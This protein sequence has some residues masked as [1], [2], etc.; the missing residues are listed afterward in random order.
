VTGV[1]LQLKGF[2]MHKDTKTPSFQKQSSHSRKIFSNGI[3]VS[4]LTSKCKN[5][6]PNGI[7]SYISSGSQGSN[8]RSLL[9]I[10]PAGF[11]V[12]S[13]RTRYESG[14]FNATQKYNNLEI[15]LQSEYP[16]IER[17]LLFLLGIAHIAMRKYSYDHYA[18]TAEAEPD[19]NE[20]TITTS[21]S[22]LRNITNSRSND[23]DLIA[24]LH[25][26]YLLDFSV[27]DHQ[28]KS[29]EYRPSE[30]IR[31]SIK[32]SGNGSTR[33]IV[34]TLH[35]LLAKT[36]I[37]FVECDWVVPFSLIYLSE[38]RAIRGNGHKAARLLHVYFSQSVAQG[39]TSKNHSLKTLAEKIY[40]YESKYISRQ[41]LNSVRKGLA[42]L[43]ALGW[44]VSEL[45]N[46]IFCVSRPMRIKGS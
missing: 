23:N 19:E 5:K 17:D 18:G 22:E 2:Y 6:H 36:L 30:L 42:H 33:E 45:R 39:K 27:Y 26:L 14:E 12:A 13:F 34:I 1:T 7:S 4:S 10:L 43:K 38:Y 28:T 16:P 44:K 8:L 32:N 37:A 21:F 29:Y 3:L 15:T 9:S 35:E 25:T 41:N 24:S 46:D 20:L 40:G 11:P 31:Y